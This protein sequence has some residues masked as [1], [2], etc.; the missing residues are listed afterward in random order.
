M[1]ERD[2]WA[3]LRQFPHAVRA[4]YLILGAIRHGTLVNKSLNSPLFVVVLIYPRKLVASLSLSSICSA[5]D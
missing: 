5:T 3:G 4:H 2:I 1:A